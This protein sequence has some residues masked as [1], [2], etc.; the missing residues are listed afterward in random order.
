M[1][2]EVD[3]LHHSDFKQEQH[4]KKRDKFMN[5]LGYT[6]VR[7]SGKLAYQNPMGVI[8]I[9]KYFPKGRTFKLNSESEIALVQKLSAEII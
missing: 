3:G 7:I 1:V 8:S 9:L 4:D 2:L 6:V 5:K